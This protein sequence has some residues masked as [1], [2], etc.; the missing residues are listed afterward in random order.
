MDRRPLI[1]HTSSNSIDRPS[2]YIGGIIGGCCPCSIQWIT[3]CKT[4]LFKER[5]LDYLVVTQLSRN[6]F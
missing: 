4:S 2:E 5:D 6:S 3:T 1:D